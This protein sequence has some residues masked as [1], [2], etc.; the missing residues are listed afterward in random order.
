MEMFIIT[1]ALKISIKNT[2]SMTGNK[3]ML[4]T[5]IDFTDQRKI[6]KQRDF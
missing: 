6:E 5:L 1:M 3:Q 2:E 4:I